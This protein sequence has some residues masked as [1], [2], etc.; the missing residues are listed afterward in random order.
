MNK[1]QKIIVISAAISATICVVLIIVFFHRVKQTIMGV[2]TNNYFTF[3]ELYHSDTAIKHGIDNTPTPEARLNLLKLRENILN[4]AREKLG[5]AIWINSG[6]RSPELNSHPDIKGSST[7]D[8]MT[9]CA[10]D[11][12]THSKKKNQELFAILVEMGNFDQLIWE[13]GGEWIHVSYR[14][15]GNRGQ[16]LAQEGSRYPSIKNNWQTYIA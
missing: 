8:H 15:S 13:N 10:A 5:S 11:L 7:S 12:D 3:N 6:Y 16:I 2:A 1:N 14:Q 4:P 9:G